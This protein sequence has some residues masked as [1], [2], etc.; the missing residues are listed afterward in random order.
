[1]NGGVVVKVDVEKVSPCRRKMKIEIPDVELKK[2]L[3][4]VY[5]ELSRNV[6][7]PGFRAGKVPREILEK[8]FAKEAQDELLKKVIPEAYSKAIREKNLHPVGHPHVKEVQFKENAPLSFEALFDISPEVKLKNYK[9][10]HLK[11]KKVAVK[12]EEVAHALENIRQQQAQYIVV[13]ERGLRMGDM[14]I[15]EWE[16]IHEGSSVEKVKDTWVPMQ[17]KWYFENFCQQLIGGKGGERRELKITVPVDFKN[18]T[19]AGKPVTF[20]VSIKEIKEKTLPELNDEF[21]KELGKFETLAQVKEEI[22]KQLEAGKERDEQNSLKAQLVEYL[23]KEYK[24][25]LPE[26]LVEEISRE[27][28]N[29]VVNQLFEKGATEEQVKGQLE[30][31]KKTA[32]QRAETEVR[33]SYLVDEMA[34]EEKISV[35]KE[36]MEKYLG[37]LVRAGQNPAYLQQHFSK[38]ENVQELQARLL[39]DKVL[40][41]LVSQG[42]IT[43][44]D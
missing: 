16:M 26:F 35:S 6:K 44:E 30:T 39:E 12:E 36:D 32:H 43:V 4:S 37:E 11:R 41:F 42:K 20:Q 18:K 31:L 27:I 10:I 17:E 24:F 29:R 13:A 40:Q 9:G 3:E 23:N 34:K 19:V 21:A 15:V 28:L 2:E 1:M 5:Q 38:P 14:A 33:I 22:K 7:V 25:D 8:R